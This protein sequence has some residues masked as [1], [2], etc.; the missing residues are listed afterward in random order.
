[1][2]DQALIAR[3]D[4]PLAPI[5][6]DSDKLNAL[7]VDK[8]ERLL[9]MQREITAKQEQ[10]AFSEAMNLVQTELRPVRKRGRNRHTNSTYA[11]MDDVCKM[12]DPII[13]AHGFSRSLSTDDSTVDGHMRFVLTLRHIGGHVERHTIDA[14]VDDRGIKGNT[15][16]TRLHGMASTYTYVERHLLCKVFGIQ[17][18]DD[19]DGNTGASV[20]PSAE[21]INEDQAINIEGLITEVAADRGKFLAYFGVDSVPS[22]PVGR[23]RQAVSMLEAKR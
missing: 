4:S 3:S 9:D 1:M 11:L 22:L 16:K 21:R 23:Y 2:T 10:Q 18:T 7:D 14:P 5:L 8:L 20:G 15:T 6:S 19:D 13:T 17:V 12:L